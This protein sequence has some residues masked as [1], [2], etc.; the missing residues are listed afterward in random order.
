MTQSEESEDAPED[1]Q[2]L[3]LEEREAEVSTWWPLGMI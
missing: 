3:E 2:Q 1:L